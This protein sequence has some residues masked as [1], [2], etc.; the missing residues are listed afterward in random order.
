MRYKVQLILFAALLSFLTFSQGVKAQNN[1]Y[2]G[3][4]AGLNVGIADFSSFGADKFHPGWT[5]GVIGGYQ[6]N[7]VWSFEAS[8]SWG[9]MTMVERACCYD[10]NYFLGSDFKRY[11]FVKDGAEGY[12]YKDLKNQVFLQR[13]GIQANMNVLG[14][15]R[16]ASIKG[17]KAELSP[18]LY[19]AGTQADILRKSD[20]AS[21]FSCIN[22]WHLG[23]GF[24]I[25]VSYPLTELSSIAVYS[26]F[27]QF[28]GSPIDGMPV[29]HVTNC[30]VDA[31]LKF[32]FS[33]GGRGKKQ[34]D[35]EPKVITPVSVPVSSSIVNEPVNYPVN[36]PTDEPVADAVVEE[37]SADKTP[38]EEPL[39][40][41]TPV[42]ETSIETPVED[43]PIT[44]IYFS[45]NSFWIERGQRMKVKE[46]ADKMKADKS[47]RILIRAWGDPSGGEE[48]N[49][50]I[51]L[52]RAERIKMVLGQWLIPADRIEM[53]G[54]GIKHDAPNDSE[55]RVAVITEIKY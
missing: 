40:E 4:N 1:V 10:R 29:L 55:A 48:V 50:R 6:L 27:T 43:S 44:I 39:I 15:F 36:E 54:C 23:Y 5:F 32:T 53:E 31:G 41:E 38:A 2:V 3:A 12:Y 9:Q 26:G 30:V 20:N 28:T 14:F 16:N 49:E 21:V 19:L 34:A 8:G 46:L 47:I 24:N 17:L 13:Y 45:H 33:L 18:A 42:V 11:K 37:T 7:A 25:Q 35:P 52:M 22:R 51:S